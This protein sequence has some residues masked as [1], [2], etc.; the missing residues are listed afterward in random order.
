LVFISFTLRVWNMERTMEN[1]E[2]M[3][4]YA[5]GSFWEYGGQ[6]W[7]HLDC[8]SIMWPRPI[9]FVK[10]AWFWWEYFEITCANT[11]SPCLEFIDV[12][13]THRN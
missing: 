9:L 5:S 8:T 13:I 2:K 1:R 3:Q 6:M 12:L 10:I 11:C 4:S 7:R